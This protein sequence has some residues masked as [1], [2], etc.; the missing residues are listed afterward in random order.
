MRFQIYARAGVTT[1]SACTGVLGCGSRTACCGTSPRPSRR[2]PCARRTALPGRTLGSNTCVRQPISATGMQGDARVRR[3]S[4]GFEC[5]THPMLSRN[6]SENSSRSAWQ[7]A[8]ASRG[9]QRLA[10]AARLHACAHAT[11]F[12][13]S[14]WPP[15]PAPLDLRT[16]RAPRGS[17]AT[18]PADDN[19][20][21]AP[22][23]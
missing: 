23:T 5:G 6:T 17:R 10:A 9:G 12:S 11:H 14:A 22:A 21:S 2:A 1:R 15:A 3:D 20:H 7:R 8:R 13:P 16:A 4:A 19:A 18:S